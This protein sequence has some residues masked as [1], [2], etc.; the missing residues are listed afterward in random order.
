MEFNYGYHN[1]ASHFTAIYQRGSVYY[2]W[3]LNYTYISV[4]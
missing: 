3:V 1:G 4:L 2:L